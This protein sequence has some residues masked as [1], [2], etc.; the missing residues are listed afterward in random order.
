M[1]IIENILK[2][3]CLVNWGLMVC[4]FLLGFFSLIPAINK[5]LFGIFWVVFFLSLFFLL[6]YLGKKNTSLSQKKSISH[7]I[8]L[9]LN[10][11]FGGRYLLAIFVFIIVTVFII[12]TFL[13]YRGSVIVWIIFLLFPAL[14]ILTDIKAD[15]AV[16]DI[17]IDFVRVLHQ[18]FVLFFIIYAFATPLH[19]GF[20]SV[21]SDIDQSVFSRLAAYHGDNYQ[22]IMEMKLYNQLKVADKDK[23]L[24]G[25]YLPV[26][27]IYT[28][29]MEKGL[30]AKELFPAKKL[31]GWTQSIHATIVGRILAKFTTSSNEK[32][33]QIMEK[34]LDYLVTAV[35]GGHL[36]AINQDPDYPIFPR[37]LTRIKEL[38]ETG[39]LQVVPGIGQRLKELRDLLGNAGG[40]VQEL[41]KLLDRGKS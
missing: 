6:F 41:D 18:G 3:L 15:N 39:N 35:K 40:N 24:S 17:Y 9:W 2:P 34:L 29:R 8:K 11:T 30:L 16:I 21:A 36:Q 28:H 19:K 37:L 20:Y 4:I 23:P 7:N 26:L 22:E 5:W 31:Q 10:F 14:V 27:D 32:K 13:L 12:E 33:Q 1:K 38:V 25:D